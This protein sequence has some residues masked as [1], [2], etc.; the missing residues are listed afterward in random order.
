M[1]YK[2]PILS[3]FH[4]DPSVCR[5]GKDFYLVNSTFEYFPG[6]PLYHSTDL[7]HWEQIGHCLTRNSQ[8]KL[9]DEAPNCLGIYAPT[10]RYHNGRF[11]CIVTNVGGEEG[12]NFFV[13]TDDICGE[14][15]E[16]VRL[17][18]G[19]I[20]PS[21]FFDEDGKVYYCGTDSGIFICEIDI[22]TGERIGEKHYDAWA[23]TGAN[24]PEGPHLYKIGGWYY[25]MIAEG[26]TELCHME[27]IARSR[28]VFG[29]YEACP[30]NPVLTNRG[31]DYPIKAI[32]HADLVEDSHGNWWAVCLGIRPNKYPFVHTM[33][34]ETMLVPVH[35]KD[36][37]PMF[38]VDSHVPEEITTEVWAGENGQ[39]AEPWSLDVLGRNGAGYYVP[40]SR[41][42]DDFTGK[43]LHPSWNYICNP[44]GAPDDETGLISLSKEGLRLLGNEHVLWDKEAKAILCRRQE[45]FDFTAEAVM[46]FAPEQNE[47]AGLCIYMNPHHH[48]EVFLTKREQERKVILRRQIGSLRAEEACIPCPEGEVCLILKGTKDRY[49]FFV[50]FVGGKETALGGGETYYLSTEA[51]GCFTGNYIGLYA[52]GNG[53][54]A[55]HA[56]VVKRFIYEGK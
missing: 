55:E 14:W 24:N 9:S 12:G 40:G 52:S 31:T 43:E 17:E 50:R 53:A 29:P 30:F 7:I 38:G 1:T 5:V 48:Y 54:P 21:M 33:G 19:G 3:G 8:V 13:S 34:R 2:N 51:G 56:A 35:W 4:P 41:V 16:P 23:G 49:D 25:L 32:G 39:E 46:D 20:D 18:F 11:Y 27:S 10:I 45:H 47:E 26:G 6:I 15:S 44:T 37:W 28:T 22:N 42:A 36:G